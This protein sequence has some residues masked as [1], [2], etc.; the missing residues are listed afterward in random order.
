MTQLTKRFLDALGYSFGLHRNQLRK[1]TGVPYFAHIMGT[2]ALVIENGGD[3]DEAIAALLH[4]SVEDQ[5]G[6]PVLDEIR[7][8]FGDRVAEIVDGCT[9]AYSIPKRPWRERKEIY[10]EKLASA[11]LKTRR[12]SLAD[13]L[14]NARCLLDT[15]IIDG[16]KTWSRFNGGK[17][18][19]LWYYRSLVDVFNMT[20]SDAMTVEFTR[21]VH[22]IQ[23]LSGEQ[24]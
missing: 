7:R 18:G 20:G 21:V 23:N 24:R 12:V 14:H 8:L 19:T 10:L 2:T 6:L 22:E 3:E 13:K 9:D 15:I 17:Q 16:E 4:D 1:A 5:G 11:D